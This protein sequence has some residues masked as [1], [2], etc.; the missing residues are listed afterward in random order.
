MPS[1]VYAAGMAAGTVAMSGVAV[2]YEQ[3]LAIGLITS[4][5]WMAY[6]L[7]RAKP[8]ARW[9]DPADQ[10]ADA[11]RDAWVGRHRIGM[12]LAAIEAGIMASVL[13]LIIEPWL[14]LLV[15]VGAASVL[16]YGARASDSRRVRP[17][18]V[19][20]IKNVL[21]GLAYATLIG[22][23]L[24]VMLPSH[25]GLWIAQAVVSLMVM[26]DAMLSDIDD[27]PADATFGTRTMS[28]WAGRRWARTVGLG[29]HGMA[30]VLW[31]VL[32][33][34]TGGL[35]AYGLPLTAIILTLSP[36]LRTAIDLRA[37]LL[38]AVALL[39]LATHS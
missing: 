38:G 20:V 15:P 25:E 24:W 6:L 12:N 23:V 36:A 34:G 17:K 1:A 5:A 2:A 18:D 3:F 30:V 31:L 16:A 29:V 35:F 13:A 26:A 7:D 37:G 8:L 4:I 19:L 14:V 11:A 21:T 33:T 10:M 27:T 22:C 39:W 32:G 28:V 9:H